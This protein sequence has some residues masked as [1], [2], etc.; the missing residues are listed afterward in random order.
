MEN[1]RVADKSK[2]RRR[3]REGVCVC[4]KEHQRIYV[5]TD[6]YARKKE[7]HINREE[8]SHAHNKKTLMSDS[9]HTLKTR[10]AALRCTSRITP[11]PSPSAPLL[12]DFLLLRADHCRLDLQLL[13]NAVPS[14][15]DDHTRA[16]KKEANFPHK[17]RGRQW[18][19]STKANRNGKKTGDRK[20][21]NASA[22]HRR[23]T[24]TAREGRGGS[25][26]QRV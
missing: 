24:T 15:S 10:N 13:A 23:I 18:L 26:P 4:A 19:K 8:E 16:K 17:W 25:E 3:D 21:G 1:S 14:F 6:T 11:Q 22:R 7:S 12:F 2:G 9:G 20:A 5:K